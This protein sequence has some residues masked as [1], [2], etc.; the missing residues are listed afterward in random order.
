MKFTRVL[1]LYL[2]KYSDKN[3]QKTVCKVS[4][5]KG[6]VGWCGGAGRPTISITVGQRP[7]AL[8]VGAGGGYL[9]IFYSYLSSPSLWKT[10]R[11]R[12]NTVS[13]GH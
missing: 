2:L 4:V 3:Q 12:L 6:V 5:N 13:K 9:D 10:A 11:Y 1:Y 7:I 8:A